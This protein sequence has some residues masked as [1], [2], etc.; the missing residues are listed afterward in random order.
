MV[1]AS[2]LSLAAVVVVIVA[3][4]GC[5]RHALLANGV[6]VI[7]MA[8]AFAWATISV[9]HLN[10]LSVTFAVTMICVGIYYGTYY[11]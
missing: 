5:V 3:G 7:G 8:W 10:I 11:V 4:F 2:M 9:G 1:Q 6:L